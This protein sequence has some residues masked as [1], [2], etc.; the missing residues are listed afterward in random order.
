MIA[1]FSL[2]LVLI[3]SMTVVRVAAIALSLTGLSRELA[4]FQA[5]SAFT[6]AGFTTAESEQVVRHPVRRRIIMLLMLLG[7]AGIITVM[8]SLVLSFVPDDPQAS[9][10]GTVW[11]RMALLVGGVTVLWTLANSQ[12]IDRQ[13][14]WLVARALKRWTDVEVCDYAGLLH[15]TKGYVEINSEYTT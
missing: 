6:G 3:L 1:V 13:I 5:R 9:I 12:W 10:A 7:N 2:L 15:L 14:S 8:T 11:F 4:R